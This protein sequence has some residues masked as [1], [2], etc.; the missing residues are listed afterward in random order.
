MPSE[1][2]SEIVKMLEKIA[3]QSRRPRGTRAG[4]VT[5]DPWSGRLK[6]VE[7]NARDKHTTKR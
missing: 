6:A 4:G 7:E 3:A 5:Q 2:T 1:P